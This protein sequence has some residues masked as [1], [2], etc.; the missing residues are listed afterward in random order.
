MPVTNY[1]PPQP[2]LQFQPKPTPVVQPLQQQQQAGYR[3]PAP[4][5]HQQVPQGQPVFRP[6]QVNPGTVFTNPEH[7]PPVRNIQPIVNQQPIRPALNQQQFRPGPP[8][9]LQQI[10]PHQKQ[11]PPQQQ[12]APPPQQQFQRPNF[13]YQAPLDHPQNRMQAPPVAL[14]RQQVPDPTKIIRHA[15][16]QQNMNT[17]E[18]NRE[19]TFTTNEGSMDDDDND[20]VVGRMTTPQARPP[21]MQ[22]TKQAPIQAPIQPPIM[23]RRES[24]QSIPSRPPSGMGSNQSQSPEPRMNPG[25]QFNTRMDNRNIPSEMSRQSP[26]IQDYSRE[27]MDYNDKHERVQR[28][29]NQANTGQQ[30]RPSMFEEHT[31]K[32]NPRMNRPPPPNF[33]QN[34]PNMRPYQEPKQSEPVRQQHVQENKPKPLVTP[35]QDSRPFADTA[36]PVDKNRKNS[37]KLDLSQSEYI[38]SSKDKSPSSK[39]VLNLFSLVTQV[40]VEYVEALN[41]GIKR[42]F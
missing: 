35:T 33:Q 40:T 6:P 14:Q 19:R 10:P 41:N 42:F 11:G 36:K 23:Q 37:V 13:P 26:N 20:V 8:P 32:Q 2:P 28:P 31:L 34:E 16:P 29:V 24:V 30:R 18:I 27:S 3:Q 7:Q 25:V 39:R 1:Q 12:Q 38:R 22:S 5:S 4:G 9:Q 17:A 15:P 21:P